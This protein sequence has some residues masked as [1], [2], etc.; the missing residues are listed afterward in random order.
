MSLRILIADDESLARSR[1][2]QLVEELGH[3]VCAEA[4]DGFTAERL[5][6]DSNPDAVL[7]DIEMPGID[8]LALAKRLET[9]CPGIPV[10]LVTAHSEH[11][12]EAFDAQ[13][14][15]YVL[16]P[17]RRERLERAVSS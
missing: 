2:R 10:V 6:R 17:V 3:Q 9:Q 11:A 16:K 4:P 15:D 7:L 12:I 5:L 8:G 1:L 13:V 14:R